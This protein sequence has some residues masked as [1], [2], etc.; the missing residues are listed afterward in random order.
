MVADRMAQ[1]RDVLICT[2]VGVK[3]TSTISNIDDK[4]VLKNMIHT[5]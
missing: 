3:C 2:L 1:L 4:S 5:I